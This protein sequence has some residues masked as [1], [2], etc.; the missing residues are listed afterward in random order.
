MLIESGVDTTLTMGTLSMAANLTDSDK[1]KFIAIAVDAVRVRAPSFIGTTCL[2]KRDTIKLMSEAYDM[3]SDD[4]MLG[5]PICFASDVAESMQFCSDVAEVVPDMLI[6]VC[7]NFEVF[8]FEFPRPFW[9]V[10]CVAKY[11]DIGMQM[12]D[13]AISTQHIRFLAN[14]IDYFAADRMVPKIMTAFS[15]SGALCDPVPVL[16]L[17]NEVEKAKQTG[18]WTRG[19]KITVDMVAS[20][21]MAFPK[22]S[23]KEFLTSKLDI[24]EER[25][26]PSW[27]K[28]G[29]YRPSYHVVP[30][31]ALHAKNRPTFARVTRS[32][33]ANCQKGRSKEI[34]P[35]Y[36]YPYVYL[37]IASIFSIKPS[38]AGSANCTSGASYC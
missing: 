27:M 9:A 13:L 28:L 12:A 2:N 17:H 10:V 26:P 32:S 35:R 6:Y 3:G 19:Y 18:D 11:V 22:G 1:K 23:F 5:P 36:A 4:T 37:D 31:N 25:M 24:G 33:R 15:T 7:A 16:Q 34:D 14:D 29:L 20:I 8:K 30:R 21:A 38:I